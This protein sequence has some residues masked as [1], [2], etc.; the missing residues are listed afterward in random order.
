MSTKKTSKSK[1]TAKKISKKGPGLAKTKPGKAPA[2]K[3]VKKERAQF[4]S[5]AGHLFNAIKEKRLVRGTYAT[6]CGLGSAA[7]DISVR[8]G[9]STKGTVFECGLNDFLKFL[10]RE[11][12]LKFDPSGVS[13]PAPANKA[14]TSAD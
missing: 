14:A 11:K 2:A 7:G 6:Y 1:K 13:L 4:Y 8:V 5:T 3:K 12:G 10:C 9:T